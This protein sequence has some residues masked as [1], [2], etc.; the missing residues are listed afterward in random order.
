MRKRHTSQKKKK[1]SQFLCHLSTLATHLSTEFSAV[2]KVQSKI[3]KKPTSQ[4]TFSQTHTGGKIP[5]FQVPAGELLKPY[6]MH[7]ELITVIGVFDNL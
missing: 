5:Y 4:K 1:K 3:R 2:A 6:P 7:I